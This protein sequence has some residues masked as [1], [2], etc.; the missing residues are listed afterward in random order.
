MTV[1]EEYAQVLRDLEAAQAEIELLR[2]AILD[3]KQRIKKAGKRQC[4]TCYSIYCDIG[5]DLVCEHLRK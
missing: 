5:I 3:W 1:N 4:P 2:G